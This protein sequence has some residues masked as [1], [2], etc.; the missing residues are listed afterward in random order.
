MPKLR[1]DQVEE[2][3][4]WTQLVSLYISSESLAVSIQHVANL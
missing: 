3:A 2:P 4:L 1:A